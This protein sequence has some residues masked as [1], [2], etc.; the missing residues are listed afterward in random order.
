[1]SIYNKLVP[2]RLDNGNIR[3]VVCRMIKLCGKNVDLTV[4]DTSHVSD[5]SHLFENIHFAGDIS[6][7]DMRNATDISFMFANS[8]CGVD[9]SSW[10]LSNVQYAN[11]AFFGTQSL[12]RQ[13]SRMDFPKIIGADT[14][15]TA[16]GCVPRCAVERIEARRA[17][18]V[19]RLYR[20][21]KADLE[22][23]NA[24]A[25]E[26]FEREIWEKYIHS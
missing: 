12:V 6:K 5:F 19:E 15:T 2:K 10:D 14:L 25:V 11:F 4:L 16:S 22:R 24:L 1:M 20:S 26:Y 3:E 21:R 23:R 17:E 7:W 13:A 8:H 9:I 18:N